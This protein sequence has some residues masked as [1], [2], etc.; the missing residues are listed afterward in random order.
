MLLA[1]VMTE[2]AVVVHGRLRPGKT[3]QTDSNALAK[4]ILQNNPCYFTSK[5]YRK[6]S[7]HCLEMSQQRICT[8]VPQA[9]TKATPGTSDEE[10]ETGLCQMSSPLDSR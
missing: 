1:P 10:K 9:G 5:R 3:A 4:E 2:H 8:E 6:V 7:Q